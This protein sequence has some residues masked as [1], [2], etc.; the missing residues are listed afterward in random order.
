MGRQEGKRMSITALT[1][2]ITMLAPMSVMAAS[3]TSNSNDLTYE[4][5]KKIVAEK[6]KL[7][8][9]KYGTTSVQY[10]LI[11]S[12]E[13]VVSGQT[14]KN[15]LK[16]KVPLTSNTIYGIGSTSKM[17][18]TTAV[19]KLVDEGKID[20]DLPVVNYIR[21]FK[22]KDNRYKQ[23]TPRMLLNHSS[24]LLGSTGSNATLYGDN[25]TYSHDTF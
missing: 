6:A 18:L 22:M 2:V 20:L 8:T 7:L 3:A 10:A 4:P 1:L 9:E 11:D 21:D 14:G 5:T 13:I 15:D 17:V 16:D 25:D 19:M 23:I 24:G 12:G